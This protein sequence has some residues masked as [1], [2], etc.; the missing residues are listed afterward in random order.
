M[1]TNI[2]MIQNK[3]IWLEINEIAENDSLARFYKGKCNN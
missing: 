1:K 3:G 2:Y